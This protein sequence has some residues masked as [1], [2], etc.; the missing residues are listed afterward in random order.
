MP[1]YQKRRTL[2][3]GTSPY[4]RKRVVVTKPAPSFKKI[5]AMRKKK[6]GW[7]GVYKAKCEMRGDMTAGAAGLDSLL[8]DWGTPSG[9][10]AN[11][12]HL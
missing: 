3:H 6:A 8:V 10:V 9:I 7:D 1:R 4:K 11:L 2:R 12:N 5:R